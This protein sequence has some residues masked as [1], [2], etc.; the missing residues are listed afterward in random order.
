MANPVVHFQL[1]AQDVDAMSA[2]YRDVFG[3]H[4]APRALTS[5][6]AGVTGA[7]SY[8]EPEGGGTP[9]GISSRIPDKGGAVLVI[10]VDDIA[11][12]MEQVVRLGGRAYPK[13][14]PERMAM[15]SPD[16]TDTRFELEEFEDPEGN[17]VGIIQR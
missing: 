9:G 17:L 12:T 4:I 6:D 7:Y 3:W 8:I 13:V 16:G 14:Q 10:E 15:A 11:A 2:F 1:C 5:I